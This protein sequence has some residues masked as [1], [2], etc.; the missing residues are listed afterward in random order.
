MQRVT[1]W[2]DIDPAL[3]GA[4]VAMGNFDGIHR[5]HQAVIDTAR[6]PGLPLGVITFE[7]HPRQVLPPMPRP[8]G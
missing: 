2:S 3:K 6:R 1:T 5:G 7:P 4:S 8:S